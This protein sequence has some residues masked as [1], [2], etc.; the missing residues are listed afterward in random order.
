MPPKT[1]ASPSRSDVESRKAPQLLAFPVILAIRPSIMSETTKMT[2]MSTPCHSQPWGKQIS[3]PN[4]TPRVPMIVTTSGE[5]RSRTSSRAIGPSTVAERP[6]KRSS[7]STAPA[8]ALARCCVGVPA[9][10]YDFPGLIKELRKC[11]RLANNRKEVGVARPAG[12]DVLV[13]VGGDS[14]P[15]HRALVDAE[16]ET[17]WGTCGSQHAHGVLRQRAEREQLVPIKLGEIGHV[18]IGT[19][20][21]MAGRIGIQVEQIGRAS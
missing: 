5:T 1:A 9:S 3:A 13:Q 6:L 2:T 16:V 19:D 14:G 15:R 18:P 12:Y 11:L 21:Q 8:L 10:A 7:I 4:T 17:V 20:Q